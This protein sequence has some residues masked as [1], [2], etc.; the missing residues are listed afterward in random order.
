MKLSIIGVRSASSI[1]AERILIRA[2]NDTD[3]GEYL[4]ADTTYE[5]ETQV[6]NKLRHILWLPDRE[7]SRGDLIVVYTKDG[8][9]KSRENES[10]NL[11]HFIYWGLSRAIWN[12]S[13]DAATLFHISDWQF[14][15]IEKQ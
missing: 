4:L 3:I 11:T 9:D 8:I 6:S 15:K 2:R 10:G 13:G 5:G 12:E 14:K 7:V 1:A